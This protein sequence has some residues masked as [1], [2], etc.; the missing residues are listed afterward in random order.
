MG[1]LGAILGIV[2]SIVLAFLQPDVTRHIYGQRLT[3]FRVNQSKY[4]IP[5]QIGYGT[6]RHQGNVI[7]A[8]P[9]H[10][11]EIIEKQCVTTGSFIGLGG[12]DSC[13]ELHRFAYY[14]SFAL[15][16]S[17]APGTRLLQVFADGEL[18]ADYT[19]NN[20]GKVDGLIFS[21]EEG[22]GVKAGI[23]F[24]DGIANVLDPTFISEESALDPAIDLPNMPVY[25]NTVYVMFTN[26]GLTDFG[27][28][29]PN[30]S[31]VVAYSGVTNNNTLTTIDTT[32][33]SEAYYTTR[34]A[35]IQTSTDATIVDLDIASLATTTTFMGGS[36]GL[37]L[38]YIDKEDNIYS[39]YYD[40]SNTREAQYNSQSGLPIIDTALSTDTAIVSTL[41]FDRAK[42]IIF[43]ASDNELYSYDL[44]PT[45]TDVG[46]VA[47]PIYEYG[48]DFT[49][50]GDL[51][52]DMVIDVIGDIWLLRVDTALAAKH[53]WLIHYVAAAGYTPEVI[54]IRKV[55]FENPSDS[56]TWLY[57]PQYIA[58]GLNHILIAS[59]AQN[60]LAKYDEITFL[61]DELYETIPITTEDRLNIK[62]SDQ[63]TLILSGDQIY[64]YVDM[65]ASENIDVENSF[66]ESH[67]TFT[68][69]WALQAYDGRLLYDGTKLYIG[70]FRYSS[71]TADLS[72]VVTD[73]IDGTRVNSL[74]DIT[75]ADIDTTDLTGIAVRGYRLD[76]QDVLANFISELRTIYVFDL[77]ESD[78]KLKA[79][80]RGDAAVVTIPE[81]ELTSSDGRIEDSKGIK[82]T[83]VQD[84][85]L[86]KEV[87]ISYNDDT[88]DYNQGIQRSV[89]QGTLATDRQDISL[90]MTLSPDEAKQATEILLFNAWDEREQLTLNL[91]RKYVYLDAADV[92]DV[93][94]DDDITFTVRIHSL[95][96]GLNGA[97]E[98][99]LVIDKQNTYT[100]T[101]TG[102]SGNRSPATLPNTSTIY[103][104]IV[105]SPVIFNGN[106]ETTLYT[107]I[108]SS[109]DDE[110]V[111]TMQAGASTLKYPYTSEGSVVGNVIG[112]FNNTSTLTFIPASDTQAYTDDLTLRIRLISGTL[113]AIVPDKDT[114]LN[115]IATYTVVIGDELIAYTSYTNLGGGVYDITGIYRNR[116]S[117]Q[118]AD[119]HPTLGEQFVAINSL[120]AIPLSNTTIGTQV[121]MYATSTSN[122]SN[123]SLYKYVTISS[124]SSLPMPPEVTSVTKSGND[125]VLVW[126]RRD[127]LSN[128]WINVGPLGNS[129]GVEEYDVVTS[130]VDDDILSTFPVSD[131]S[132]YTYTQAQQVTDYGAVVSNVIFKVYQKKSDNTQGYA[133]TYVY[134]EIPLYNSVIQDSTIGLVLPDSTPKYDITNVTYLIQTG[135]VLELLNTTEAV[136]GLQIDNK[137]IVRNSEILTKFKYK[138]TGTPSSGTK[139]FGYV[140]RGKDS[141]AILTS[142]NETYD[143]LY[144]STYDGS[145]ITDIDTATIDLA[146][147]T[148][149][150][151]RIKAVNATVFVKIWLEG[152]GEPS[153]WTLI[154]IH[155]DTIRYGWS[156][157][158][159]YGIDT[160]PQITYLQIEGFP[161]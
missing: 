82:I 18:I 125:I 112:T 95:L 41:A 141:E 15:A 25:D 5:L 121:L 119:Y 137:T 28:R 8:S 127:R 77:I 38:P 31:V 134:D 114:I 85:E 89:M 92:I 51:T 61:V 94:S 140:I 6:I 26:I 59:E 20:T 88:I 156:G 70:I 126:S 39:S 83:R 154:A 10:E 158:Y 60:W 80:L 75:A 40:G 139:R 35:A 56:S 110:Y 81:S 64:N 90:P 138:N 120:I 47:S 44:F 98:C 100:S 79:I 97:L 66:T 74:P 102:D 113:E 149:Y 55:G 23:T 73:I 133:S 132:T 109:T 101:A 93:V 58:N 9:V 104:V 12:G 22:L 34:L 129:E 118:G 4:G 151:V 123:S 159:Q 3:Q 111:L 106:I 143:T 124:A 42:A 91:P 117:I 45:V 14:Q 135:K 69:I 87:S 36:T 157:I 17:E 19:P 67:D 16:I 33:V 72:D 54:E 21:N 27:N 142:F 68:K 99:D 62:Y 147:N 161:T 160:T 115:D 153:E 52:S 7:W 84:N 50:Y 1:G 86:P 152:V 130:N 71:A 103:I 37:Y 136:K 148:I 131:I 46:L 150:Y 105:D 63:I 108:Y 2:L 49:I 155:N 96:T 107:A 13:T 53:G 43:A 48:F 65:T 78:G 146:E 32:S 116:L 57:H 30:I 128:N 144:I 24:Y 11:V 29:I 76:Q 122:I 145:T